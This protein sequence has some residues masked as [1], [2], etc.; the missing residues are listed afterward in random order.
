MV[1]RKDI[2]VAGIA[3]L[4]VCC[5]LALG[6]LSG[7]S[8]QALNEPAENLQNRGS[9][10]HAVKVAGPCYI[11]KDLSFVSELRPELLMWVWD[12]QVISLAA[13][14]YFI[15]CRRGQHHAKASWGTA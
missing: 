7:D 6:E 10:P 8:Q 13:S 14:H 1:R 2:R 3:S 5:T 11:S 4:I 12:G 15:V 9:S